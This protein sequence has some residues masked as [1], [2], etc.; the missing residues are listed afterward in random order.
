MIRG[1]SS[2]RIR[3]TGAV[4]R[5]VS[6]LRASIRIALQSDLFREPRPG[7]PEPDRARGIREHGLHGHRDAERRIREDEPRYDEPPR[8]IVGGSR[9]RSEDPH[10][11]E[12]GHQR[13]GRA[14]RRADGQHEVGHRV[15]EPV[16]G[17]TVPR[18]TTSVKGANGCPPSITIA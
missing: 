16:T 5:P 9:G 13:A 3:Q 11:V 4:L 7:Q 15:G 10:P 8:R 17:F 12:D 18:S 14:C 6:A 2:P 1:S